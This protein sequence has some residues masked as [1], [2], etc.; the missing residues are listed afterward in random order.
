YAYAVGER[1]SRGIERRCREDVAFRV[2][3]A[4]QAPDH[5]TCAKNYGS[6]RSLAC[7]FTRWTASICSR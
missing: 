3:C 1:S 4:N 5:A 7:R 6:Y 2:I